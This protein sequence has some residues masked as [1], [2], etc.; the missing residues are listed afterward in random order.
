MEGE[1]N[2]KISRNGSVPKMST[3][4]VYWQISALIGLSFLESFSFGIIGPMIPIVTTEYFARHYTNGEHIDCGLY[5]HSLACVM[6]SKD[7]NWWSSIIS[8]VGSFCFFVI[9]PTLGQ[10]SD[11]FGRKPF[12]ASSQLLRLGLPFSIMYFTQSNGSIWPY[13]A[14]RLA[15]NIFETMGIGSAAIADIVSPE[16]R[17][18]AFGILFAAFSIGYCISAGLAGL[19]T[20]SQ[21]LQICV[22]IFISRVLWAVFMIPETLPLSKRKKNK[23]RICKNPV[24]SLAILWRSKLFIRLTIM[25]AIT[26]FVSNGLFQIRM[27]YLN[28]TIGFNEKDMSHLMLTFGILSI[29]AQIVLLKPLMRCGKEKGVII[30]SIVARI[31]ECAGYVLSA[32][33]PK[34]WVIYATAPVNS[35]GDLSFAAISSLKSINCSEREQGRLQGAIYA[36]RAVFEAIGPVVFAYIYNEMNQESKI[37]MVLPF[38]ISIALYGCGLGVACI[39]PTRKPG[40]PPPM[41]FSPLS[42]AASSP[43]VATSVGTVDFDFEDDDDEDNDA[44]IEEDDERLLNEPLLADHNNMDHGVVEV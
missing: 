22:A 35:I 23:S 27:F 17:A 34:P 9:S 42:S 33:V 28:T 32:F 31:I 41:P 4:A 37:S 8:A 30:V 20:R 19:F 16:N 5:P 24:R 10:A 1:T 18:T 15:C 43:G 13:F 39:L 3:S 44:D 21:V 2:A 14:L 7:A 29:F 11:H 26:T 6:G 40:A 12:I 38:V 25:I 36:A